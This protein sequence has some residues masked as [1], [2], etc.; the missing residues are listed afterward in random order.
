MIISY[1][2]SISRLVMIYTR[3][4]VKSDSSRYRLEHIVDPGTAEVAA[5]PA[6]FVFAGLVREH[7]GLSLALVCPQLR[8]SDGFS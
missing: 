5:A 1:L 2:P 4:Q 6:E 3:T 7:D 8:P